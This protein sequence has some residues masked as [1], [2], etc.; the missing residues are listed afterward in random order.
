MLFAYV[1]E[2]FNDQQHWVSGVVLPHERVNP[3]NLA[4]A[5]V[6]QAAADSYGIAEAAELHG[7]ELFQG[8]GAFSGMRKMHRARA[9]IYEQALECVASAG[10]SII[11]RGVQKPRLHARYDGYWHPHRVCMTHL[12]ERIDE[13]AAARDQ[14]VLLI[15]DEHHEMQSELLRDLQGFQRGATWG[16]RSRRITRVVDTIHFV[17]SV[18][19]PLIQGADLIAFLQ[20]RMQAEVNAPS[21]ATTNAQLWSV[22]EPHIHHRHIWWP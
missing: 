18:A 2:S 20:R 9:G 10:A 5:R 11:L 8:Q 22:I 15:A 19:N 4:L 21:A 16:Y 12:I 3:A 13:F 17:R 14:D 7:Y 1:D 6:V